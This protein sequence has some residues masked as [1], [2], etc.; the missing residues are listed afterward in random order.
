M[1]SRTLKY[2]KPKR[3]P[4]IRQARRTERRRLEL[5]ADG[6]WRR[7]VR[8][9]EPSG[10]CPVCLKRAWSDAMHGFAKGMYPRVRWEP[11]NGAPGCRPCHRRI[12]SDHNAKLEFWLRYIGPERYERLRLLAMSRPGSKLDLRLIVL[13]LERAA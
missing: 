4:V 7:L 13:S 3:T 10:V 1:I 2:P 9:K 12:D 8:A 6:L 5:R 11:D